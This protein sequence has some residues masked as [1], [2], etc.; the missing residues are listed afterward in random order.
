MLPEAPRPASTARGNV[1]ARQ[2]CQDA[3]TDPNHES[4][5]SDHHGPW[6]MKAGL[7]VELDGG[8]DSVVCRRVV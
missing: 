2:V 8:A 5:Q 6:L 7:V 4:D 3:S 1:P